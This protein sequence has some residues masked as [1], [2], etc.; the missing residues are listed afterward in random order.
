MKLPPPFRALLLLAALAPFPARLDAKI[1]AL[2]HIIPAG[3]LLVLPG[4]GDTV[5]RVLVK[6]GDLL[7]PGPPPT[8]LPPPPPPPTPPQP[9]QPPPRP[10]ARPREAHGGEAERRGRCRR[11]VRP[12]RQP[13]RDARRDRG[14]RR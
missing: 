10:A 4:P 8:L 5:D 6:E 12:P 1:G 14:F 9:A 11:R 7:Q 13:R 3:D 2:G